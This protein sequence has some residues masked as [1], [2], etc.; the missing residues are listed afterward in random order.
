VIFDIDHFQKLH[1]QNAAQVNG[2]CP[3]VANALELGAIS[4]LD[5]EQIVSELFNRLS[6]LPFRH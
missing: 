1:E 4:Q 2:I 3:F 5:F 6:A